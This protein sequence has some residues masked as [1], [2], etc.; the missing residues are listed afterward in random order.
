MTG[1]RPL[2]TGPSGY[3]TFIVTDETDIKVDRVAQIARDSGVDG[4][5]LSTHRNFAWVT[6][7]ASNRIDISREL[8]AGSLL[9]SARGR[10][11][12]IANT[13]EMPRLQSETLAGLGFAAVEY[14]WT[15]DQAN[16]GTALGYARA[17]I[18]ATTLGADSPLPQATVVEPSLMR[19]RLDLVDQEVDRYRSL[20]RDMGT[21]I[22]SLCLS[23][24]PGLSE[25]EIANA[26]SAVVHKADARPLVV[27]VAGDDRLARFRH[28]LPTDYAWRNTLMVVVC[29]ERHGLIVALS[30]IVAVGAIDPVLR[31]RT[32]RTARV[33]GALVERTREG[34]TGAELFAAAARAYEAEGFSGEELKH[35][36]GGAIGYRSREWVAHPKSEEKV[37]A[38]GAFA[39]NPSITGSKVEDTVLLIDSHVEVITTSPGWPTIDTQ[40][41]SAASVCQ[42]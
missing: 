26:V 32:E 27:L 34:T 33:F 1:H 5:L 22:G 16:P 41:A 38:R 39:W 40:F 14:P 11:F 30:R 4:I 37:L 35:H 23:L 10:R 7:G 2:A 8:G 19:A 17:A 6:G 31:E 13:I 9:I 25:R 28:P 42:I 18:S 36:Q 24:S 15:E 3:T 29:A 12:V 20:G 21:T